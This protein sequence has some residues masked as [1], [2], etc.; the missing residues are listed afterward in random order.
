MQF[1]RPNQSKTL[2][3]SSLKFYTTVERA[4][5]PLPRAIL[6]LIGLSVL[7]V[8]T[9]VAVASL[10]VLFWLISNPPHPAAFG[11]AFVVVAVLGAYV[12]YRNG[13]VRLAVSLDAAEL[14]EHRAPRLYQRINRLSEEMNIARPRILLA[15]LDAPNALS[16]GGPRKGAVIIDRRMTRLLTT[17]ELE[18]II[19]HELAHIESYDTFINTL[20][21]TVIRLLVAIVFMLLFPIFVFLAGIDRAAG[22]IVGQPRRWQP[23]LSGLFRQFVGVTL[24]GLLSIF[25]LLFLAHSRR[26]E[27]RA[28]S[29]AA[30]ITG[31]PVALARALSKIHRA[32]NQYRGF[33]SLLYI[34]DEA[35]RDRYELLSTHPPLEERIDRLLTQA[36]KKAK[37]RSKLL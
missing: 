36:E 1:P 37:V 3:L 16:V 26:Q 19:A 18:G 4:L 11:V 31:N 34:H 9:V 7:F 20:V 23:G 30:S 10:V 22:W 14:P 32:T 29:R 27:Y 24:I 33:R 2:Y 28:D 21:L 13:M 12:G 8:Y 17:D 35:Q 15:E 5:Q 6:I 25:T